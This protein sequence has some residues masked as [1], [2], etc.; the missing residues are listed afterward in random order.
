MAPRKL[1]D[2][3]RKAEKAA[4]A[5]KAEEARKR[6][7]ET[8]RKFW[9]E[10]EM[11]FDFMKSFPI[12]N[13]S[14]RIKAEK[15][16]ASLNKMMR[17]MQRE[18]KGQPLFSDAAREEEKKRQHDL[19]LKF[20]R[21]DARWTHIRQLANIKYLAWSNEKLKAKLENANL[22]LAHEDGA[23]FELKD[24]ITEMERN[25]EKFKKSREFD[26]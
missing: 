19:R 20:N 9:F 8:S 16:R 11:E 1:K 7:E 24:N 26:C 14:A 3:D 6:T 15:E 10:V 5:K 22:E 13:N 23:Q 25:I 17:D 21:A 4:K 12:M 2:C 18:Y